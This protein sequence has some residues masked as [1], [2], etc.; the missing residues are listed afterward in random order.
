MNKYIIK[1]LKKMCKIVGA[2][3][4]RI[5]F[6]SNDWYRTYEWTKKQEDKFKEWFID[7]IYNN[8]K[9]REELSYCGKNKKD[10]KKFVDMFVFNYGWTIKELV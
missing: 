4:N 5:D 9:A 1:I 7:F 2:D 6:K 8:K 10:I 3:F